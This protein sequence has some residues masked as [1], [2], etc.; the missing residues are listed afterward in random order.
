MGNELRSIVHPQMGGCWI[1]PEKYLNGVDHIDSFA[2]SADTNGQAKPA[3]F[4]HNIQEFQPSDIHRLVEL[5]VNRPHVV[6]VLSSQQL[7]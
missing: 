2:S 6:R 3:V 5:E 7:P 1:L 4:I